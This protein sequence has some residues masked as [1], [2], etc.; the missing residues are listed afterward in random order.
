M[1]ALHG[2]SAPRHIY[3]HARQTPN[4]PS[5]T[6]VHTCQLHPLT[7]VRTA[8]SPPFPHV[9]LP[10]IY[11]V[12]LLLCALAHQLTFLREMHLQTGLWDWHLSICVCTH[13]K[14]LSSAAYAHS[15]HHAV[16]PLSPNSGLIGWV[17]NCDTLHALI[18][19]FRCV[20]AQ[21]CN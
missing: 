19:E 1:Y 16:I 15:L 4:M 7:L 10:S 8:T 17:P 9:H 3:T 2:Q 18:R 5:P 12:T 14:F 11:L 6:C 20:H 21:A 13:Q